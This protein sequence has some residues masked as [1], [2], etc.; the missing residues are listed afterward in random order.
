MMMPISFLPQVA[1]TICPLFEGI[2]KASE[3][4]RTSSQSTTKL[5]LE[6]Q[7]ST[8][9]DAYVFGTSLSK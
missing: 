9:G 1:R 6:D 7:A 5:T 3:P 4:G 2:L 8:R